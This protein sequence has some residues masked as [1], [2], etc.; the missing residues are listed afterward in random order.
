[1]HENIPRIRK[2]SIPS[3]TVCWN[4]RKLNALRVPI[5][6]RIDSRKILTQTTKGPFFS[7]LEA[8]NEART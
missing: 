8:A 7:K 3:F 1:M 4:S 5:S 2:Y 6:N